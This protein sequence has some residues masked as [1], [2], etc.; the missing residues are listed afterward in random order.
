MRRAA[1]LTGIALHAIWANKL[2]SSL[3]ILGNIVAVGSIIAVVSLIQGVNAEV[4]NAIVSQF[5]PDSFGIDR[6]PVVLT[7][8]DI[9]ATRNNPACRS[10]TPTPFGGSAPASAR[11]WP[12]RGEAARCATTTGCWRT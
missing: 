7:E 3:T 2:R 4:R 12:S 11:S 6:T 1:D 8:A 10:T 9:E 5:G